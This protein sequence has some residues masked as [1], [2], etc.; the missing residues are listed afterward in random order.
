[1]HYKMEDALL[2]LLAMICGEKFGK[3]D[4][5]IVIRNDDARA[6]I[7]ILG[8][9]LVVSVTK[10]STRHYETR[11]RNISSDVGELAARTRRRYR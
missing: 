2:E 10:R 5:Y 6:N 11:G 7:I 1:M 9:L 8:E 3:C 4:R